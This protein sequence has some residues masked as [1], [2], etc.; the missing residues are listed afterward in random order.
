[1]KNQKG[2]INITLVVV[3]VII[4]VLMVGVAWWYES[5]KKKDSLSTS[6]TT[7]TNNVNITSGIIN[8]QNEQDVR[9]YIKSTLTDSTNVFSQCRSASINEGT[10]ITALPNNWFL[11]KCYATQQEGEMTV[12]IDENGNVIDGPTYTIPDVS[13]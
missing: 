10:T 12:K 5:N 3:I 2:I 7:K 13:M 4:A 9:D 1:M 6:P 8:L 11:V